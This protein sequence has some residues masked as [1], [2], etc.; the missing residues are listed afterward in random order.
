MK[1]KR[2]LFTVLLLAAVSLAACGPS[3][4]QIATMT[5]SAW[6][7][8]PPP[9]A[10]PTPVPYDVNVSIVDES[11]AP[12]V[13]A[14]IVFPESGNGEPVQANEQ[15]QFSWNNLEGENATFKV[16]TQGYFP[17]DQTATIQRGMN[18]V[19]VTL[20]R[21]PFAFLPLNACA[22]GETLLYMDD[23]QDGQT[24]MA[25]YDGS[26]A[27]APLGDAPDETGNT[28]LVHDF[29]TPKGDYSSYL[30][31]NTTGAFYEF[32]DA[33]WR[34][35]FMMTQETNLRLFWN[36]ARATEFGGITTSSSGYMIEFNTNRHINIVR[37]IWDV[38]GQPVF[39][40][41]K[42]G[43]EDKVLIL[44]PNVWHYLETSTYQGQLQVWLDG[45]SVV[46]V[47]DDMPLPPG[48]FSIQKG[49]S[50]IMYFDA[51]SVCG[52]SA[53]FTS[54]PSPIPAP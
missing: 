10:T 18:E 22:A 23:F 44:D 30:T 37:S 24:E 34:L 4:E 21:D 42:P 49:D 11:G 15:G 41:G 40:I 50:G 26:P 53:P 5:A 33:V 46:D 1:P 54:M 39:N 6:T 13:G 25:H 45:A 32:G 31:N 35:R 27:P 36:S 9:T 51:I 28:V 19:S 43:L 48:G 38:N 7:P 47:V 17:A 12:I 52:L 3:P 16:T 20:K 14:N 29:T 8:T 2:F